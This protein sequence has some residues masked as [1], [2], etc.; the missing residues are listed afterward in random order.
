MQ[1]PCILCTGLVLKALSQSLCAAIFCFTAMITKFVLTATVF[2]YFINIIYGSFS[3]VFERL[4]GSK[5]LMRGYEY[6]GH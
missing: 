6:I 2:C 1:A 4:L 3:Y 5:R